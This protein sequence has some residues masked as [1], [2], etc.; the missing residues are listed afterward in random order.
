MEAWNWRKVEGLGPSPNSCHLLYLDLFSELGLLSQELF[1]F[2]NQFH[3]LLVHYFLP[4]QRLTYTILRWVPKT[5]VCFIELIH[6]LP[7]SFLLPLTPSYIPAMSFLSNFL[8]FYFPEIWV[9]SSTYEVA[10]KYKLVLIPGSLLFR[11]S[12]MFW[13]QKQA[14]FLEARCDSV[15]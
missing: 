3:F 14:A 1:Y 11:D 9:A 12:G 10:Q 6:L 15:L 13:L 2:Q 8:N 5:S 7:R 4:S